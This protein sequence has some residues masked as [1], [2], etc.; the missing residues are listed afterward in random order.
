VE[1]WRVV[2]CLYC[3]LSVYSRLIRTRMSCRKNLATGNPNLTSSGSSFESDL[4]NSLAHHA[5]P[6]NFDGVVHSTLRRWRGSRQCRMLASFAEEAT[7]A[8]AAAQPMHRKIALIDGRDCLTSPPL[9]PE[10][11]SAALIQIACP[12]AQRS[13]LGMGRVRSVVTFC[14]DLPSADRQNA[15]NRHRWNTGHSRAPSRERQDGRRW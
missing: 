10:D 6:K 5:N 3:A 12:I 14:R 11:V 7:K 13:P 9:P 15:R 8:R 1:G 2:G 4:A